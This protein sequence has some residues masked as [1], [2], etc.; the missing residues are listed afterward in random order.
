MTVNVADIHANTNAA[1][2]ME[3][4]GLM[5]ELELFWPWPIR[6]DISL[7]AIKTQSKSTKAKKIQS[8]QILSSTSTLDKDNQ[9]FKNMMTET[10]SIM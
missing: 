1:W 6:Y 3:I 9:V 7:T 5:V 4:A 8:K 2:L 10:N